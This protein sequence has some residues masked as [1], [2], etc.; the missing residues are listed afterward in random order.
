MGSLETD[1]I[2]LD[3][4]KKERTNHRKI[5]IAFMAALAQ[6]VEQLICNHQVGGSIPPGGTI[7]RV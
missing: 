6:M 1:S 7:T 2:E 5:Y 3:V 4:Y